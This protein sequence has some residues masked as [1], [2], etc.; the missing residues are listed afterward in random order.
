MFVTYEYMARS[1][2]NYPFEFLTNT[3]Q[4]V[5]SIIFIGPGGLAGGCG[6]RHFLLVDFRKGFYILGQTRTHTSICLLI[7]L[8]T[9]RICCKKKN[10]LAIFSCNLQEATMG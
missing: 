3:G 9:L 5:P 7:K 1:T 8:Q 6:F 2:R 10:Q 4:G